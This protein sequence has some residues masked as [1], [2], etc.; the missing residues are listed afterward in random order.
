MYGEIHI[1]GE[2]TRECV[3]SREACPPLW[4]HRISLCGVTVA[5]APYRM[6]RPKVAVSELIVTLAGVGRVW[7][8]GKW[9]ELKPEEAY[10]SPAGQEQRFYA[11]GGKPWSFVWI[12]FRET[13]A[14][15][16]VPAGAPRVVRADG[17]PLAQA[18]RALHRETLGPRDLGITTH[19]AGLVA[20]YGR[21]IGGGEQPGDARLWRVW[22]AVDEEPG[23]PWSLAS[24]AKIAS[25]SAEHLRRRCLHELGKSPMAHV[26]E[27]RMQRAAILLTLTSIKIEAVAENVGYGSLCTFSAAFKRWAGMPPSIY[28]EK[29]L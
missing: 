6:E 21:R 11:P 14:M 22:Q 27:L 24:M 5:R 12:H 3:V 20:L 9:R 7:V 15:R 23:R 1:I 8:D 25:M 29:A 26:T 18:I 4:N 28:R 2:G 19:L 17:E 13:D 10:V 16:Y